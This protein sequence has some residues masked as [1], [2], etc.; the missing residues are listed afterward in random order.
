[1]PEGI[2]DLKVVSLMAHDVDEGEV[3]RVAEIAFCRAHPDGFAAL[4]VQ[5][6]PVAP[7][8][9]RRRDAQRIGARNFL[10]LREN[11]QHNIARR[12]NEE[13]FENTRSVAGVHGCAL[14]QVAYGAR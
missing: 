6:A 14:G 12:V 9:G 2:R 8:R 3:T 13:I 1:M 4:T 10:S 7:Q 11:A 5:V